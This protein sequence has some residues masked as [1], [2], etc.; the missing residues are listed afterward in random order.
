MPDPKRRKITEYT[1]VEKPFLDELALLGWTVIDGEVAGTKFYPENSLRENF[2]QVVIEQELEE[3]LL[4]INSWLEPDQLEEVKRQVVHPE[5]RGL[6]E[7]NDFL[8]HLWRECSSVSEN[9]QTGEKSP[10][11]RLI[12]FGNP[13]NNSFL[14]IS[15][16]QL[17]VPGQQKHI[18]PDIVLFINGIPVVAVSYTHLTLPTTPYV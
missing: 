16:Y 1:D 8:H 13:E 5:G 4:R 17:K 14:A 7:K 11:V 9:R 12:D 18:I 10:N 2:Q 15:Q 3:A 6:Q